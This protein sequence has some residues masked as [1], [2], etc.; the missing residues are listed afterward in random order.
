M[1]GQ[2]GNNSRTVA[3]RGEVRGRSPWR[4]AFAVACVALACVVLYEERRIARLESVA[5]GGRIAQL[6]AQV[7]PASEWNG[8]DD[9]VACALA[10]AYILEHG[11]DGHRGATLGGFR[12]RAL[13]GGAERGA[14]HV[15][16][17]LFSGAATI[18]HGTEARLAFE[19]GAT[20]SGTSRTFGTWVRG[21]RITVSV[22]TGA[23]TQLI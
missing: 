3:E 15:G 23:A 16:F 2:Q 19:E 22:V 1:N 18:A 13:S 10:E 8:L 9:W 21:V 7:K 14:L 11:W 20:R 17:A 12:C 6:K 4:A 5:T